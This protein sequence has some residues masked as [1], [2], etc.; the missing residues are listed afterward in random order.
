M[1]K[2]ARRGFTLVELLV[3]IG[4]IAV[5]VGILLPSLARAR[6]SAKNTQCASQLRNLGQALLM[7]A[8]ENRGKLPQ[9]GSDSLWLWDI[10]FDTRDAMVKKGG[11][12]KTLYCPVD[13]EQDDTSLWDGTFGGAPHN[14]S[15]IGY[16]WIGRRMQTANPSQ[17][18][19]LLLPLFARG[20][21][22]GLRPPRPPLGTAPAVAALYPTKSSDVEVVTDCVIQ[23]NNSWSA[24]GGW[25]NIHVTSHLRKNQPVGGN[26]LYMD[27][28][29]DFRPFKEMKRRGLWGNPQIAFYF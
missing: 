17:Q 11:T 20:Y 9:H 18:S 27:W 8:N 1:R 15:V 19:T 14:Y 12:R 6:E 5:L 7:Y 4:I 10:P 24:M 23:Q 21:L 2:C 26:I 29:V 28:H 16:F 13:P 22:D 25:N 3:V